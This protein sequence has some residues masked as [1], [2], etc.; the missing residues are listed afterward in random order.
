MDMLMLA[1][2]GDDVIGT[3]SGGP[4]IEP[5][6][7]STGLYGMYVAESHRGTGVAA[8]LVRAIADWAF[9][10]GSRELYLQVTE[11]NVTAERLYRRMGFQ[12]TA[13]RVPMVRSATL[14]L[15]EMVAPLPLEVA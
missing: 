11:G 12:T 7:V 15:R 5:G 9:E 13:R 8:A 6:V 3:A 10:L 4:Y 14:V 1:W 2:D